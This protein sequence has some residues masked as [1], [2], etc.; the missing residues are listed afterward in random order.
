MTVAEAGQFV[1][2]MLAPTLLV[3]G[4]LLVPRV[5][6]SARRLMKRRRVEVVLEPQRPPIER[7][8]ADL[9]RLLQRHDTLKQSTDVA[10]RARHLKALEGAIGDCATEAAH[11]LGVPCPELHERAPMPIPELRRLLRALADAGLVLTPAT[12][13]MASDG[14]H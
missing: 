14:H 6:R 7:L 2:V 13:L 8:A 3:G 12:G 5:F 11:A 10:M 4:G 1:V 9:R